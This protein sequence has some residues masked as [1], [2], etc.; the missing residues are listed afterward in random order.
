M[1]PWAAEQKNLESDLD[2][3]ICFAATLGLTYLGCGMMKLPRIQDREPY[4]AT[5]AR[6]TLEDFQQNAEQLNKIGERVKR[7][8]MRL[9]Y[10]NHSFEFRKFGCTVGYD[11]LM[12]LTDPDLV[13]MELDCAWTITAGC[14]PLRYLRDYPGRIVLIHLRDVELQAPNTDESQKPVALGQGLV[15]WRRLMTAASLGGVQCAF[16][17]ELPTPQRPGLACAETSYAY[18]K[19]VQDSSLEDP[20][21]NTRE[22]KH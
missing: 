13:K 18:L 2:E 12:R 15:N 7:A 9:T 19:C 4:K 20:D 16:V 14:D 22:G 10:H 3:I 5:L 11:E 1:Q 17:E 6:L 21:M 8:G